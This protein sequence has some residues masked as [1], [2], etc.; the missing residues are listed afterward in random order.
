MAKKFPSHPS[1]PERICWGC[2]EFCA[3]TD[4]ACSNERSPHP[5]ELFGEDWQSWGQEPVTT[6]AAA[7]AA[8]S[9]SATL[10]RKAAD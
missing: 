10:A 8:P 9:D 2:D 1:H 5:V 6:S 3:I 7:D 4:M